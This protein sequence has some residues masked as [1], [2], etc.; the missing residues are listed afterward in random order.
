MSAEHK[1]ATRLT[2]ADQRQ[3]QHLRWMLMDAL[4]HAAGLAARA[5]EAT[6]GTDATLLF[7]DVRQAI[8][9]FRMD[10]PAMVALAS[11]AVRHLK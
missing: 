3:L 5:Q 1:Q 6:E 7:N 9:D 4:S 2:Q 11:A 8:A 10:N